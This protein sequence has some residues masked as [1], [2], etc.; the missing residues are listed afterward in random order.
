MLSSELITA[1]FQKLSV[2]CQDIAFTNIGQRSVSK[3]LV[4]NITAPKVFVICPRGSLQLEF[5]IHENFEH[6]I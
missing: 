4:L 5:R 1:L 3:W 2:K 6:V